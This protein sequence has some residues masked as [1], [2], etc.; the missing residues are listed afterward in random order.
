SALG[1]RWG[2]LDNYHVSVRNIL[3]VFARIAQSTAFEDQLEINNTE[4]FGT[5]VRI[6]KPVN[7]TLDKDETKNQVD[8]ELLPAVIY[9]HG[10]G[11]TIGGLD[12]WDAFCRRLAVT[13]QVAVVST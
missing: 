7:K 2:L 11:W 13:A 8:E 10:G 9:Y 1:F 4:I 6:Y 5:K 3:G 12:A